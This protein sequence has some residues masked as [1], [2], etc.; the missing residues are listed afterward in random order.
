[1]SG[2]M[3]FAMSPA[4]PRCDSSHF[5]KSRPQRRAVRSTI[6]YALFGGLSCGTILLCDLSRWAAHAL[7]SHACGAGPF[8]RLFADPNFSLYQQLKKLWCKEENQRGN[9]IPSLILD[10]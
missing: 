3:R 5:A 9:V 1:M 2:S 7:A 10:N 8:S 4:T 6:P